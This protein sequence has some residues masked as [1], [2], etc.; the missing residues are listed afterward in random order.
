MFRSFL[1]RNVLFG[2]ENPFHMASNVRQSHFHGISHDF[3]VSAVGS[4]FLFAGGDI[5]G[6]CIE[7]RRILKI[8]EIDKLRSWIVGLNGFLINAVMLVPAYRLLEL[9]IQPK[10]CVTGN[11]GRFWLPSFAQVI[12]LQ[13]AFVPFSNAIFLYL[14]PYLEI[15]LYRYFYQCNPPLHSHLSPPTSSAN[16]FSDEIHGLANTFSQN[17]MQR[18]FWDTYLLSW[19]F[20]PIFSTINLRFTPLTYRPVIDSVGDIFWTT[21]LTLKSHSDEAA[22]RRL[23]E[24][25]DRLNSS[26]IMEQE[27]D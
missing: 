27:L 11:L 2:L 24:K 12:L 5:I 16:F 23:L 13:I 9:I 3:F 26:I 7:S 15:S 1:R 19:A 6:Q 21:Y 4:T 10:K 22:E 17:S 20:W 8:H 25:T 14:T 18:K